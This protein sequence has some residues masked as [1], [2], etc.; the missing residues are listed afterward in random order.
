MLVSTRQMSKA[1]S[2]GDLTPSLTIKDQILERVE[3]FKLLGTWLSEDL[4]WTYQIKE[5][6]SFRLLWGDINLAQDSEHD[7][8]AYQK[9]A[10]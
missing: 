2:L 9:D 4:K 10:S 5:L 1:H 8:S 3:N 6:V 7:T